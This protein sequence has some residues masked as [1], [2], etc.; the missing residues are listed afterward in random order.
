MGPT[1]GM[2][3][4][5]RRCARSVCD[6]LPAPPSNPSSRR[7][8]VSIGRDCSRTWPGSSLSRSVECRKRLARERA[9]SENGGVF[10]M[11]GLVVISYGN[12]VGRTGVLMA[13][14]KYG[15]VDGGFDTADGRV[16]G[17][18]GV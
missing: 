4:G 15:K 2:T 14:G 1:I 11:G 17:G 12:M 5:F 13:V 9:G 10:R 7:T 16:Y 18:G 8:S 3:F 6:I